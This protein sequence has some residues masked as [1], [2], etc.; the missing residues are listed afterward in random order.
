MY[1]VSHN[2]P[3]AELLAPRRLDIAAEQA[4][5]VPESRIG[6]GRGATARISAHGD[7]AD[8]EPDAADKTSAREGGLYNYELPG[9]SDNVMGRSI[10]FPPR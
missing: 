2:R 8:I 10:F 9:R 7:Q 5:G 4:A 3:M 1:L 6:G